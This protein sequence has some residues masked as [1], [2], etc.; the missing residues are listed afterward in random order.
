MHVMQIAP[1]FPPNISEKDSMLSY[2][3]LAHIFD[4]CLASVLCMPLHVTY[5]LSQIREDRKCA[6]SLATLYYLAS[7]ARVV[8]AQTKLMHTPHCDMW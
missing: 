1:T 7:L 5:Q 3:P 8:S 6:G 4:R 2:L